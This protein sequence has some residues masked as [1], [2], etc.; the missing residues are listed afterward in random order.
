MSVKNIK[1]SESQQ[2]PRTTYTVLQD[3]LVAT[4]DP[5]EPLKTIKRGT[6]FYGVQGWKE[7]TG[8]GYNLLFRAIN[9]GYIESNRIIKF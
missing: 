5:K 7:Q 9:A 3:F 1:L 8:K 4:K 2:G 6:V